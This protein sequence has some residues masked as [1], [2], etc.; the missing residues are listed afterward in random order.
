MPV[1]IRIVHKVWIN[2]QMFFYNYWNM[3]FYNL[4]MDNP[5]ICPF[6][7]G[8]PSKKLL[9]RYYEIIS[10]FNLHNFDSFGFIWCND[11]VGFNGFCIQE[12]HV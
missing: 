12:F 11:S 3:V 6:N 10:Y 2:M 4:K 8:I 5:T 1:F 9:F 7:A